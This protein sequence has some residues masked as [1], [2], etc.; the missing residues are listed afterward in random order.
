VVIIDEATQALEAVRHVLHNG[1]GWPLHTLQVCWIPIFKAK[2]LILAGDPKQL[3]P[4]IHS[5][6][7]AE[8]NSLAVTTSRHQRVGYRFTHVRICHG[9]TDPVPQHERVDSEGDSDVER[10]DVEIAEW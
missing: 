8:S 7:R 9:T 5:S 6:P 3:P 10:D 4:T 2:K 1:G